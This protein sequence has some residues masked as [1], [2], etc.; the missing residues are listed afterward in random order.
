MAAPTIAPK[1][2]VDIDAILRTIQ[3]QA[4]P[5][6]AFAGYAAIYVR[7][8]SVDQGERYSLPSQLKAD[9]KKAAS[10]NY[11]VKRE[12]IFVDTHSGKREKRPGFDKVRALVKT[13]AIKGVIIYS[14]D[15]FS[16]RTVH[17]LTVIAEFKQHGVKLHFEEG[18]FDDTPTGRFMLTQMAAAA[19]FIGEKIIED[20]KRGTREKLEEGKL[21]HGSPAFGYR[22][23]NKREPNGARF[24]KTDDP[25]DKETIEK[26]FEWRGIEKLA[27]H[28]IARRL[29]NA[30]LLSARGGLWSKK[31]VFQLLRNPTYK[32]EHRRQ[33]ITVPCPAYVSAALWDTA[34][35]VTEESRRKHQGRPQTRNLYLFTG[36]LFCDKPGCGWRCT[37]NPGSRKGHKPRPFYRCNNVEWKPY[38][39]RCDERQI[40]QDII[41]PA[42]WS[43]I[44]GLLKDPERLLSMGKAYYDKLA[45]ADSVGCAPLEAERT[46]L[47][48]SIATTQKMMQD[49]LMAYA[50]GAATI[51]SHQKR[52]TEITQE[53]LALGR[54]RPL[55]TLAQAK[56]GLNEI[57]DPRDEPKTHEER[58]PILNMII[59]L[60]LGY[61]KG[62]LKITGKVP[63]PAN[64]RDSGVRSHPQRQRKHRQ[65]GKRAILSHRSQG[66]PQILG[67]LFQK[68]PIPHGLSSF[69][70]VIF[71]NRVAPA[72]AWWCRISSSSSSSNRRRRQ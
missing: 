66:V 13:G 5:D 32:G 45:R 35:R 64:N 14:V 11:R 46:R 62:N 63:I 54:I 17:T 4:I 6:Q 43:A 16:R 21:T 42:G 68:H 55:P 60:R 65:R 7:V 48:N 22:Y 53:L 57:L 25:K 31:T 2:N 18:L 10:L 72:S 15:R 20:S 27:P 36:Y 59:D 9:L 26:V 61:Y 30:G 34:Q 50:K 38:K 56:A 71:P 3:L 70:F 51:R 58:R 24:E 37:T 28:G 41:E 29:N 12:H 33:G 44:W 69:Q 8:S 40:F 67:E 47:E 49:G 23:I 19:E 39:R 1:L 52:I